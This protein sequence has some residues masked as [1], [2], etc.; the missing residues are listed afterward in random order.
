M[1]T[2]VQPS[3]TSN[4]SFGELTASASGGNNDIYK[5]FD[6]NINSFWQADAR[7]GWI[8]WSLPAPITIKGAT[9]AVRQGDRPRLTARLYTDSTKTTPIGDSITTSIAGESKVVE[10][11]PAEGI[12]TS[13][14]YVDC[15]SPDDWLGVSEIT[16]DADTYS[17]NFECINPLQIVSYTNNKNTVNP[18]QFTSYINDREVVD[19]IMMMSYIYPPIYVRQIYIAFDKVKVPIYPTGGAK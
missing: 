1:G 12:T 10:N 7:N 17:A 9:I 3:L 19:P 13:C 14:I 15:T 6:G 18:L 11:I 2:W 8:K 16:I 4:T 5:A